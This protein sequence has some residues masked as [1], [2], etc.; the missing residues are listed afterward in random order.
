MT[1]AWVAMWRPSAS[2]AIELKTIP[3][4]TSA[5]IVAAHKSSTHMVLRALRPCRSPRKYAFCPAHEQ[6]SGEWLGAAAVG[7]SMVVVTNS[8]TSSFSQPFG[9][10]HLI[11]SYEKVRHAG[12]LNLAA[13]DRGAKDGALR[14]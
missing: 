4:V 8:R 1:P 10:D 12:I 7:V 5:T 9:C 11:E 3:A 2:K 14:R 6:C 13:A